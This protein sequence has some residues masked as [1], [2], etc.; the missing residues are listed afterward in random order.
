MPRVC[1]LPRHGGEDQGS[2]S[3]FKGVS[4]DK[5]NRQWK[6]Y[7]YVRRGGD[8]AKQVLLGLSATEEQAAERVRA[9]AY[10]LGD[11]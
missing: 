5:A 11:R 4:F 3:R 6:A 8:T 9:A 1:R 2:S 7:V 10:I